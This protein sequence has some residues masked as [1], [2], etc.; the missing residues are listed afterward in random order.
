MHKRFE[1]QKILIYTRTFLIRNYNRKNIYYREDSIC[2]STIFWLTEVGDCLNSRFIK[3]SE[4]NY[5]SRTY[6]WTYNLA[7]PELNTTTELCPLF[8]ILH[9]NHGSL[10]F[11]IFITLP[12][13]SLALIFSFVFHYEPGFWSICLH[14]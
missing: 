8:S 3:K 13:S 7:L 1:N 2:A 5:G 10:A 6:R 9:F 11:S 12:I 14:T 4:I